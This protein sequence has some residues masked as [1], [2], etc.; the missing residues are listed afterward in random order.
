MSSII[1]IQLRRDLS[2]NW[3]TAN[4]VLKSGEPGYETDTGKLKFGDGVNAWNSL[5]YFETDKN[6]VFTQGVSATTWNVVH[7][8]NKRPSAVIVDSAGTEVKGQ[9]QHISDNQFNVILNAPTTG[10]VYVN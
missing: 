1:Q 3:T 10:K 4:P 5:G 2:A 9:I 8:L 7:N 6:F